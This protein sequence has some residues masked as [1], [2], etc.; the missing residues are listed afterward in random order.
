MSTAAV[1]YLETAIVLIVLLVSTLLL[2]TY[3]NRFLGGMGGKSNL[4]RATVQIAPGISLSIVEL[5]GLTIVYALG[6]TGVTAL[7]IVEPSRRDQTE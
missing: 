7:Q 1:S 2:L 3:R 4:T 6:K 5:D